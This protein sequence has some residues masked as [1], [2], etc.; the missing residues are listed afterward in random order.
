MVK[1]IL[2]AVGCRKML[3]ILVVAVFFCGLPELAYCQTTG[4]VL[5]LQQTPANGGTITPGT[6]VYH[7][8]LNARIT[9]TAVPQPGYQF[10]YW[11][12]DVSDPTLKQ[13]TA[14]LN[15]PKIIVAV[16]ERT[17]YELEGEA[18]LFQSIPG[19]FRGRLRAG[20]A[21]YSRQGFSGGGRRKPAGPPARPP[22]PEPPIP[23]GEIPV[24][25][26]EPATVIL[27]GLGGFLAL[28]G[29]RPKK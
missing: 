22:A 5:L 12:G 15:A 27:L 14:Y 6:G 7:I 21:D 11:L 9:L 24:P 28:A 17:E 16:F 13:T 1:N 10:V 25:I 23:P 18:E 26:P 19:G 8:K 4:P 29:R 20:A 2:T 3:L